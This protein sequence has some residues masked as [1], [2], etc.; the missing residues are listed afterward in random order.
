MSKRLGVLALLLLLTGALAFASPQAPPG[1][2]SD[3]G[4]HP[5]G[6]PVV[7]EPVTLEFMGILM[8]NTR[9]QNHDQTDTVLAMGEKTNVYLDWT[10]VPQDSWQERKNLVVASGDLPD[11]FMATRSLSTNEIQKFGSDGILIALDGLLDEYAPTITS[12]LHENPTLDAFTRSLDGNIYALPTLEDL[13]FDSLSS[14]IIR[15]EWLDALGLDMPTTTEEFYQVLKAF[16]TQDPNGNGLADEIPFSFLYIDTPAEREVKREHYW[17]FPAFGVYDNPLHVAINDSGVLEFTANKP[18]WREAIEYMH[19]LYSEELIDPEVFSQDRATLT[20]K[21]RNELVIGAYTDYRFRQSMAA[22][23]NEFRFG[24]M[25]PLTGPHGDQGWLRAAVGMSEGAFALTSAC[26]IPEVAVRYLD[27]AMQPENVIQNAYGAFKPAGWTASEAMIPSVDKP[28]LWE[29]NS[30]LRPENVTPSEW[31]F[32]APIAVFPV[33][34][35]KEIHAQ[36]MA[37]KDS[38]IAKEEVCDVYRPYLSEYPYNFPYKF[39]VDEIEELSLIQ[40]DLLA[41]IYKTEAQWIAEGLTDRDWNTYLTQ[42]ENLGMDRYV[43]MYTTSYGRSQ[44]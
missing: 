12:V 28:G 30:A 21:I 17:I 20:N 43:E 36:Y 1:G 8:N 2:G 40:A 38:Q 39:T 32:S 24:V 27:Y 14:A 16:K 29:V 26:E 7:D 25:A 34:I 10:L 44:M 42:L 22:P 37:A 35:T 11:G 9:L 5:T 31:P 33:L 41:Y 15:T 23:E 3:V 6:L 18:E 13:G 19:R 4:F